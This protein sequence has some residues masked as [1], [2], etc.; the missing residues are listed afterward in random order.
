MRHIRFFF[1]FF[2]ISFFSLSAQQV[3]DI[4]S[5]PQDLTTSLAVDHTL[6]IL[7]DQFNQKLDELLPDQFLLRSVTYDIDAVHDRSQLAYLTGLT[8]GQVVSK[9]DLGNALFYLGQAQQLS[10]Q[11]LKISTQSQ[12]SG[13][14]ITF[15]LI[16]N[17]ILHGIV[18]TG[19]LRGK[20]RLKNCYLLDIGEVFDQQKH[21]HSLDQMLIFL[22][23]AGY[24]QAKIIDTV[25]IDPADK[26]VVVTCAVKKGSKFQVRNIDVTFD[27]VGTLSDQDVLKLQKQIENVC[28][29]KLHGKPYSRERIDAL[30]KKIKSFLEFAGCID[31]DIAVKQKMTLDKR[32]VDIDVHISIERKR[33]FVFWGAT[34]FKSQQLMEHLLLYGKSTWHF[35][36]SLIIDE[37]EQLYKSKGFWDVHV[38][39]REE[40][41]K[42][43]CFIAQGLR[44]VVYTVK[45]KNN[46]HIAQA[47]L[48]K[49]AFLQFL[50][51]KYFDQDLFKKSC[52]QIIKF[53]RQ[54]GFWDAKITKY[55]F[56]PSKK[57]H[58]YEL[59]LTLDEGVKKLYGSAVILEHEDMQQQI[60]LLWG[61]YKNQGFD[62]NIL[63]EQK[64]WIIK[65]LRSKGYQ[66]VEVEY[67]LQEDNGILNVIWKIP[68]CKTAVKMGKTI[69]LGNCKI[70]YDLIMQELT[71]DSGDEW[72][73]NKI[74][75][76]LQNLRSIPIFDSVHVSPGVE[77]DQNFYKPVF[78]K[79]VQADSY[80]VRTRFGLQ[81]MG[82]N[83]QFHRG[84][85]YKVGGSLCINNPFHVADQCLL[86]ADVT[87]F[88]R[89]ISA[90]YQFPWLF[91][92]KIGCQLKGYDSLYQQ[93][94]YIGS[95]HFLYKATQQGFLWNMTHTRML[96]HW[97]ECTLSG[98][99]GL[100][101]MGLYP[102]DQPDLPLI[103]DYDSSL[104]CQKIPYIFVEPTLLW[105]KVDSLINPHRGHMSFL[106]CKGMFDL[107]NKTS[108]FKLLV[109]HTQYIPIAQNLTLAVRARCGHIFNRCFEQ[110]NPI[111]RFYLGGACSLRGYERDYC[112][113]FGTLTEPIYDQH[114]GLPPCADNIWRYAPQGGR[115]LFNLNLDLRCGVY[116]NLGLVVFNDIGALFKHSIYDELKCWKDNFFGGSGFGIR[117]DTPI[118][119]LRF[120]V[121]FKW[122]ITKPDFEARC[123]WYLTIG[124]AF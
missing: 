46:D 83:L 14:D 38:S 33:E 20:E 69:I 13:Y 93:P 85:T 115:S 17:H 55:E 78:V 102:A 70:P 81:Q 65:Y 89:N 25:F 5:S 61:Q 15:Q 80:E 29:N 123:V 44:S 72:D 56:V 100:E 74:E 121:G 98:S 54:K 21:Q 2:T 9:K 53:Y 42:V 90:S 112:P 71:Y 34:F 16:K 79:L 19:F 95:Q 68:L 96:R 77:V 49:Q 27:H 12:A 52:E 39:V 28:G 59:T 111:E 40:K 105:Q 10:L 45:F 43:F 64:Q 106:S 73:K 60:N 109:E 107:D 36:S 24:F 6:S 104:L 92:R 8:C 103:I 48:V 113:P 3:S 97:G 110:I 31:F 99:A 76:S 122:K 62:I 114:A 35:P 11:F 67:E 22:H 82:R 23:D 124:Q 1:I 66:K 94:V 84:F 91:G 7:D 63:Q 26:S 87:K 57:E 47:T 41:N 117:Y 4:A 75:T 18:V 50:K 37:I 51:A 30:Y 116:K 120:D 119:P 86:Q 108:F 118:G 58:T 88:Y 32:Q 101:F